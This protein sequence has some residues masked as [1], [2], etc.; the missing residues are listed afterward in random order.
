MKLSNNNKGFTMIELLS[1]L[2]MMALLASVVSFSPALAK[3]S[4]ARKTTLNIEAMITRTKKGT[5]VKTGDVYMELV[6]DNSGAVYI[7][8]YEDD[9]LKEYERLAGPDVTV[10]YATDASVGYDTATTLNGNNALIIAFNRGSNGFKTLS[11]GAKM[12]E[13]DNPGNTDADG[14]L[15]DG[16][17][18][19]GPDAAVGSPVYSTAYCRTIFVSA[20]NVM[21]Q[22]ELNPNIG[23]HFADIN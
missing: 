16:S 11:A 2:A 1:V 17:R 19:Y 4:E 21:Y 5:L 15:A 8:Y 20:A 13:I 18:R 3:A 14:N 7:N 9:I 6:V 12:T 23:T 22:I 10:K